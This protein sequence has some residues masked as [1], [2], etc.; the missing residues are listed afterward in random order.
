MTVRVTTAARTATG[1]GE[2][3]SM[4]ARR[5]SGG[6][7][8]RLAL[9]L[10]FALGAVLA[11]AVPASA[12]VIAGLGSGAG[13]VNDPQGVAVDQSTGLLY[14][15]DGNNPRVDE[16]TRAGSFVRA[17]GFGV[18]DGAEHLEVCTAETSCG[19]GNFSEAPDAVIP[20]GIVASSA[21]HA[22]YVSEPRD[23][24]VNEY[25]E[26]GAFV[27]MFGAGVDKGPLHPGNVC[28][29][30]FIEE[31]D[32]C[33]RGASSTE[34]GGFSD[35]GESEP[36]LP[37]ALDGTGNVWVGDVNRLEKFSP[38]GAFLEEVPLP[39]TGF[40]EL[41]G[42]ETFGNFFSLGSTEEPI[43]KRDAKGA[44]LFALDGPPG[45][46]RAL[47]LGGSEELYVGDE[48]PPYH[49]I[50]FDAS[51][52]EEQEV[53]GAG[54]VMGRPGGLNNKK[55]KGYIGP[56]PA[57]NALAFDAAAGTIY[58][59][60]CEADSVEGSTV[61]ALTVPAPGPL[62][63][64][65]AAGSIRGTHATL[66]AVL[67]AEGAETEYQFEY[68]DDATFKAEAKGHEFDHAST[69][70]VQKLAASFAEVPVSAP[71][72]GLTSETVY[73][74]R[75]AAHN[76]HGNVQTAEGASEVAT[77]ETTP[78]V[79]VDAAYVTD[80]TTDSA[81]LN[82]LLNP[83]GAPSSFH[84]EYLPAAAYQANLEAGR[85]AFVGAAV[86]PVPDGSLGAGET[87][88]PVAQIVGGLTPATAYEFRVVGSNSGG[89][90]ASR[91]KVFS[92]R[93]T[94]E[95]TLPD[96]REWELVSPPEKHGG[97]FEGI[98][99]AGIEQAAQEGGGITY[100]AT[101]PTEESPQG[102]ILKEQVLSER[103]PS[104]WAS[105]DLSLPHQTAPGV[106]FGPG[107][108]Y[109]FFS[110]D[111]SKGIA[112]PIGV[113]DPAVSEEASEET[114]LLRSNFVGEG[115]T[116]TPCVP[117]AES[118]YQPLVIGCPPPGQECRPAVESHANVPPGTRFGISETSLE[119]CATGV[120]GVQYVGAS[121]DSKH[122]ILESSVVGLTAT[123]GD[124]GGLYEWSEGRLT[125]LSRL[126]NNAPAAYTKFNQAPKLGRFPIVTRA[127]TTAGAVNGD[128]TRV[129]WTF[130]RH[131]YQRN[132]ATE[133][134]VQIDVPSAGAGL[135]PSETQ[136]EFEAASADGKVVFFTDEQK[137]L[138]GSNPGPDRPDLYRC[139]IVEGPTP[140]CELSDL[141]P[142]AGIQGA[143]LGSSADGA[144]AYFAADG[145]LAP[146]A[147][148]G[149]CGYP[150]EFKP[151]VECNL[152]EWHEGSVK[153][154]AA[155][156]GEDSPDWRVE[157]S[158]QPTRVSPN[159][160]WLEFMSQRS[161]TGYEN[162]DA[163]SG[164][165][166]EEVFLYDASTGRLTCVSCNPSGQ[167]PVGAEYGDKASAS[168]GGLIWQTTTWIAANVPGWASY[169]S[170]FAQHQP[171]YLSDS[172]RLFFNSRDG[173]SATDTNS[174][175]DVYEFEPAGVGGCAGTSAAFVAA[176]GGCVSLISS[177]DSPIESAFL[178][179][180]ESGNDVFF[181]T[182]APLARADGDESID[183][184]DAHVCLPSDPCVAAAPTAS[185][186]CHGEACQPEVAGP[187]E[188]AIA[189]MLVSGIGN[190][191][192][193]PVTK[194]KPNPK[195]TPVQRLTRSL[196]TCRRQHSRKAR[197]KCEARARQAY[198]A[199][200]KHAKRARR[201]P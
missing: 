37:L 48:G 179:A 191:T 139:V 200:V 180:S 130:N 36:S 176:A 196:K 120:C 45:D 34:P 59:A 9:L 96:G 38:A 90:G 195:L 55:V 22:V 110:E 184:Y 76:T 15:A 166:D 168:G 97:L 71:I 177:G 167:R 63:R 199:A 181:L 19:K 162:V 100:L 134:T 89:A 169:R 66:T 105:R 170:G 114:P 159:G 26:A 84:F 41:I 131:L 27:T 201:T 152:Y 43:Q 93:P 18:R 129:D 138:K 78:P 85:A 147:G 65:L 58:A 91:A 108:E 79:E 10:A 2:R 106:T 133:K 53:F 145:A 117:S 77:F 17:F 174:A 154:V 72:K 88:I 67:D 29:A 122:V 42:L 188:P 182:A 146:G 127:A 62:Q 40:V 94:G 119:P 135:Q 164:E 7:R 171:R 118:C 64:E 8:V 190:L 149:G 30:T 194:P 69:T 185:E 4:P 121:P 111:L 39:G 6:V 101:R 51:S 178:D 132:L 148:P 47:T 33:G 112:Q 186:Q 20:K 198:R 73:H 16:F 165:P 173:L 56:G 125:L 61:S 128:G 126:P 25:T 92:T 157:T 44:P 81:T 52:G 113:F 189:S 28:S 155:L 99:D 160:R 83:E 1:M 140:K 49:L 115:V 107:E 158:R 82:G 172:G 87:T 163:R 136:P 60:G 102:Y 32:H 86:A 95:A 187:P 13:Q 161:L 104:G 116:T 14:V 193:L 54:S 144:Y 151:N 23:L 150:Q 123:S 103:T 124:H 21:A 142:G 98:G 143:L 75:V 11:A 24:R 70:P 50:Q 137:L 12:R 5:A 197:R 183:V 109:R 35:V 3:R 192:P 141:T 31:G 153:F 74:F 175:E 68:V 46:P 156:S 80:V 57:G